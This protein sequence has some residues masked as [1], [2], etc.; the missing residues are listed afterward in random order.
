MIEKVVSGGQTGVDRAALDTALELGLS[1]GGW[2]PKGR[3]AEDGTLD[4]V[5][6][7]KET[8]LSDYAQR[9]EWNVRDSD[10]T[11]VLYRDLLSGGSAFTVK[12][13]EEYDKPCLLL[14]LSTKPTSETV[15]D[16]F[17]QYQILI[18]NVAGTRES[19]SPGIYQ[20][21]CRFLNAILTPALLQRPNDPA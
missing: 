2:C 13:A 16:W 20:E 1:C 17:K 3:L 19:G 9:T 5:Y 18:L 21:A 6:P 7:L 10:G 15:W 11:L 8:P 4:E 12:L 14:D